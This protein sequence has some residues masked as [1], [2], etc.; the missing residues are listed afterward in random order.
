MS[1]LLLLFL[2]PSLLLPL[3]PPPPPPLPSLPPSSSSLLQGRAPKKADKRNKG[4]K[5][6]GTRSKA[7]NKK[8]NTVVGGDD[9][10]TKVYQT[11]EKHR[12]VFFTVLLNPPSSIS[13]PLPGTTDPDNLITCD[14]M[15]GRDA[16]LTMARERH[17]EFSSLRRAKFSTMAML[18]ELHTQAGDRFVY[19]CNNCRMAVETRY[20][21]RE[22]DV[23][24]FVVVC[25]FV[26]V[27]VVF[28]FFVGR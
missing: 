14:L 19:N 10:S 9:L 1:G 22:C 15:D 6:T 25:L 3:P 2:P 28:L 8:G 24:F 21:C 17:W 11:M 20:H 26:F 7:H 18:Y 23:S 5:K 16:F 12:D 4:S 27:F 13:S